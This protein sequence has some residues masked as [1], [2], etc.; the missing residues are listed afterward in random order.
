MAGHVVGSYLVVRRYRELKSANQVNAGHQITNPNFVKEL[1]SSGA[2][3]N[4]SHFES[5]GPVESREGGPPRTSTCC[6]VNTCSRTIP[7]DLPQQSPFVRAQRRID[8]CCH[9]TGS[10]YYEGPIGCLRVS[11]GDPDYQP[12]RFAWVDWVYGKIA[13]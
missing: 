12:T 7:G 6:P 5:A 2:R 1:S 10:P 4:W 3:D 11:R 13:T 8:G 9:A